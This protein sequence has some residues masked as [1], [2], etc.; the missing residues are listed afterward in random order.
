MKNPPLFAPGFRIS[1]I[2][3]AFIFLA[4]FLAVYLYQIS[5]ETN[6]II[7]FTTFHFFMFC[8]VFRI[9]RKPELIWSVFF[10][11]TTYGTLT[12]QTPPWKYNFLLSLLRAVILI[13]IDTTKK[14]YHCIFWQKINP[15]I[16]SWWNSKIST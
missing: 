5:Q 12:Y 3:M 10:C 14:S 1:K 11:I 13:F 4:I 2:D 7:L 8:N 9:E 15:N 16:Q 6:F